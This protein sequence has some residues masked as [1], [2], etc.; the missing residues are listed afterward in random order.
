M[1]ALQADLFITP[2][3]AL[4]INI[5]FYRQLIKKTD[6]KSAL[7]KLILIISALAFLINYTWEL[8]QGPLYEG[9]TYSIK[10]ISF[11]GLASIADAIM[12]LLLYLGFSLIYKNPF[13]IEGLS[14][15]RILALMLVG[16]AGAILTEIRHTSQGNW[17][18]KESMPVIPL[19]EAGL[20][21][22]L[23]FIILPALT[24][25]VSFYLSKKNMDR[26]KN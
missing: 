19:V 1:L 9:Y 3:L 23:Q 4:G 24:Y 11:C 5:L 6:R 13:W 17:A 20:T 16:G 7:T 15:K 22:V 2:L 26:H 10:M 18:Y 14:L 21:P 8:L 12:T 25:H